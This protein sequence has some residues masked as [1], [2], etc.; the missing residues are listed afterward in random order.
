MYG[1]VHVIAWDVHQGSFTVVRNCVNNS[2][3]VVDC[4][5]SNFSWNK[6]EE[7]HARELMELWRECKLSAVIITHPDKDHYSYLVDGM[8]SFM[9]ASGCFVNDVV[10]F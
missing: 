7:I 10:F 6:F 8:L 9:I 1:G 5:S 2:I 4:G 3:V